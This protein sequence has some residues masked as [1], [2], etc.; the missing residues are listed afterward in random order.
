MLRQMNYLI[1]LV[2]V[3]G[4]ISA[5]L[6]EAAGPRV[7]QVEN[8]DFELPDEGRIKDWDRIPGWSSDAPATDSGVDA[9]IPDM[10]Y[11]GTLDSRDGSVYQTTDHMITAGESFT[12]SLLVTDFYTSDLDWTLTNDGT[13]AVSLYYDDGTNRTPVAT[14]IIEAAASQTELDGPFELVFN[15]SDKPAAIGHAIGIELKNTT[16]VTTRRSWIYFDNIE[17]IVG[18]YGAAS[19]PSPANQGFRR[20]QRC[21]RKR[22]TGRAGPSRSNRHNL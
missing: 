1:L 16:D 13:L 21:R 3:L 20:C 2:G 18:R 14:T 15:V 5:G 7:V 17:L 6:T 8:G 9:R 4:L 19:A 22:S 12:L 10:G 11:Q